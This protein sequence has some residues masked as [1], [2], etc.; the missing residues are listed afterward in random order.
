MFTMQSF[1]FLDNEINC[2]SLTL[3]F[4]I[5]RFTSGY[6]KIVQCS[7]PKDQTSLPSIP[8]SAICSI[9]RQVFEFPFWVDVL[10]QEEFYLHD[11][12]DVWYQTH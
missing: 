4:H 11:H 9:I 6:K 2:G 12:I 10:G 8:I 1:F 3:P 5:T 7:N